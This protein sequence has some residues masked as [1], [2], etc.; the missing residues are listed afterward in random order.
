M[1]GEASRLN[2]KKGGRPKAQHTIA[3]ESAKARII[4]RVTAEL[5]AILDGVIA[6]AKKGDT[7]A[8]KELFERAFGKVTDKLQ[9]HEVKKLI[10]FDE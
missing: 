4:Q 5:D 2:G 7:F 1:A 3:T 6:K 9:L 8:A 10:Q